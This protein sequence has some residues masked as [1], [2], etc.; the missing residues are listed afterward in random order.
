MP[1]LE[2]MISFGLKGIEVYHP[3]H[4]QDETKYYLQIANK[5][6]LLISGGSDY[7]GPIIKP[8]ISLG[9]GKNNNIKIE[10]LP[11]LEKIKDQPF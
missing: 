11:I 5:Y 9:T 8:D 3:S 6:N 4:T 10:S 2:R 1:L 7:H